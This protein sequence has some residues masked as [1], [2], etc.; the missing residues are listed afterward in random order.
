MKLGNL[1]R[2]FAHGRRQLWAKLLEFTQFRAR[3]PFALA[4]SACILA[5][6]S[7]IISG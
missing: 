3:L 5:I 2:S 4:K 7:G 6:T 1:Y